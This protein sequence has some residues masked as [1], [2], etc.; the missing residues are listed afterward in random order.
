MYTYAFIIY[1]FNDC[2]TSQ[3]LT[4]KIHRFERNVKGPEHYHHYL[5]CLSVQ[6]LRQR[7]IQFQISNIHGKQAY[8]SVLSFLSHMRTRQWKAYIKTIRIGGSELYILFRNIFP[9]YYL[10][11]KVINFTIQMSLQSAWTT[12]GERKEIG[13]SNSV[14]LPSV[15]IESIGGRDVSAY[16]YIYM[17]EYIYVYIYMYICIYVRRCIS[18]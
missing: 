13:S 9:S 15:A 12:T 4:N 1:S 14:L 11:E 6:V 5:I 16:M 3:L 17:Y 2:L 18:L 7:H 10:V 8:I